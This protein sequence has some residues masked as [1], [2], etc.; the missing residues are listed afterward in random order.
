[1]ADSARIDAIERVAMRGF[2]RVRHCAATPTCTAFLARERAW[3]HFLAR[4]AA[5][6]GRTA[7]S[8]DRHAF[9]PVAA[10]RDQRHGPQLVLGAAVDADFEPRVGEA[11]DQ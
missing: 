8:S 11:L 7:G 10:M 6:R 3:S 4:N 2:W 9:R 1:M 5:R